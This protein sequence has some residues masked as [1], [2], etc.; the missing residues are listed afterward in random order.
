ME[1]FLS[2]QIRRVFK[3]SQAKLLH[4]REGFVMDYQYYQLWS[5]NEWLIQEL[6]DHNIIIDGKDRINESYL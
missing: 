3:L 5:N 2:T 4:N 1:F 6:M